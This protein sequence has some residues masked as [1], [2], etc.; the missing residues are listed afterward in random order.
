M[1]DKV[2]TKILLK[3]WL[4]SKSNKE[5]IKAFKKLEEEEKED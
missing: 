2:L 1:E 5:W 4:A 3:E